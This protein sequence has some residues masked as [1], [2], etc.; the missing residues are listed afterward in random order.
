MRPAIGLISSPGRGSPAVV[1]ASDSRGHLSGPP[2][3][4]PRGSACS[5]VGARRMR[6][7]LHPGNYGVAISVREAQDDFSGD[8]AL[9]L[10]TGGSSKVGL[11][12]LPGNAGVLK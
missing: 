9:S 10:D 7:H 4:D 11:T 6:P 1:G 5:S 2:G 8:F 3:L 12:G